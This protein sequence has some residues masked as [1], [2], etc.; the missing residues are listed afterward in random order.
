MAK[1]Y[2]PDPPEPE[3]KYYP[4]EALEYFRHISNENLNGQTILVRG[5]PEKSCNE[6][7]ELLNAS[8]YK[9]TMVD[10]TIHIENSDETL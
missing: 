4:N 2:I 8:R 5:M 7:I 3:S 6:L 9:C 1:N 10:E